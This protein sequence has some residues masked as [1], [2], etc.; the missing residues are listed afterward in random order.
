MAAQALVSC[1]ECGGDG[2]VAISW[3][4]D[5]SRCEDVACVCTERATDDDPEYCDGCGQGVGA[6]GCGC[7]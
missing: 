3:N 4:N 5:P 2:V 7:D 1:D 6:S